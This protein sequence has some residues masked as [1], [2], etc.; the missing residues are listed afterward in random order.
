MITILLLVLVF[1]S[2]LF[3][4]VSKYFRERLDSAP[5]FIDPDTGERVRGDSISERLQNRVL[6][7]VCF[8]LAVLLLPILTN[9]SWLVLDSLNDT[10][11]YNGTL[12]NEIN[13]F[14]TFSIWAWVGYVAFLGLNIV[15]LMVGWLE[16]TGRMGGSK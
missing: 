10:S 15:F 7:Y 2:Y 4:N 13:M 5:V 9:T 12:T 14:Q 1:L 8:Q 11:A 3:F 16:K 6:F